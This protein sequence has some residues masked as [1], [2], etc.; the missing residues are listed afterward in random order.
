MKTGS[1]WPIYGDRD[2]VVFPYAP[3]RAASVVRELLQGFQGVLLTDGD[4]A[5]EKDVEQANRVVHA[6]C[7]S[8][9]R[10]QFLVAEGVEP[11]LTGTALERIRQLDAHEARLKDKLLDPAKRLELRALE[12]RPIVEEF[13][14]WLKQTLR[15][16]VLLPRHPFTEAAQYALSRER[17]LKV[18]LENP[19]LP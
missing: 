18:F 12:C 11:E 14:G 6:P 4:V 15:D 17:G 9:T 10:R 2:E 1:F 16:Y 8:H 7:W 5:Y 19:E 13:F 3:T